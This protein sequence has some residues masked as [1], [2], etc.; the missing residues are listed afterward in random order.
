M[1]FKIGNADN[2]FKPDMDDGMHV[3]VKYIDS[4]FPLFYIGLS[5]ILIT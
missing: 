1:V 3:Y 4:I 5:E 2:V